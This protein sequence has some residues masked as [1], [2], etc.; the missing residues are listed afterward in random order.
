MP[1]SGSHQPPANIGV[2][3][4]RVGRPRMHDPSVTEKFAF[5][6]FDGP[7]SETIVLE[8][9]NIAIELRIA[10]WPV[11]RTA[12]V[13]H[14]LRVRVQS[15]KGIPVGVSPATQSCA[16]CVDHHRDTIVR[17]NPERLENKYPSPVLRACTAITSL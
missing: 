14:D 12:D 15:G 4:E 16:R 6:V 3:T 5:M 13:E 2:R 9:R 11:Q 7:A 1:P 17:P 10:L 8:R